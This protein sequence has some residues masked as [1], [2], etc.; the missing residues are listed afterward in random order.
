MTFQDIINE[1]ESS[2]WQPEFEWVSSLREVSDRINAPHEDYPLGVRPTI[3][4]IEGFAG[5]DK[6]TWADACNIQKFLFTAKQDQIRNA[7]ED[8]NKCI[9]EPGLSIHRVAGKY[10]CLPNLHIN[11]GLRKVEVKVGEWNPPHPMFLQDLVNAIFPV[12]LTDMPFV[13][14]RQKQI[15]SHIE[16]IEWYKLF[17][18]IHPFEDLNGRV[19][20]IIVAA[21]SHSNDHYLTLKRT[22]I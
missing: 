12:F 7:V 9:D 21:L 11:L 1:V 6:I 20:G 13:H 3:D 17:E 8:S 19:G 2:S 4:M 18:T 16:L 5:V 14:D 15:S 22:R 10:E